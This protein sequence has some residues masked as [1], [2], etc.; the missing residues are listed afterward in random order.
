MPNAEAGSL[1]TYLILVVTLLF[2]LRERLSSLWATFFSLVTPM[3]DF[4]GLS[5]AVAVLLASDLVL[6]QSFRLD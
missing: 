4:L 6:A 2:R 5:G 3:V 1:V